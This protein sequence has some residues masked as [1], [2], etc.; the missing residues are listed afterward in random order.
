MAHTGWMRRYYSVYCM[1]QIFSKCTPGHAVLH[2]LCVEST[3]TVY[4]V[5]ELQID[6]FQYVQSYFVWHH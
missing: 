5:L 1:E 3:G 2:M 4:Y 6:K